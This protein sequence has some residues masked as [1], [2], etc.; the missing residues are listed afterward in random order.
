MAYSG[1]DEEGFVIWRLIILKWK[2]W[3]I[4]R[5]LDRL[6]KKVRKGKTNGKSSKILGR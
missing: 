4:N 2:L 3:Q 6:H 5:E 1:D